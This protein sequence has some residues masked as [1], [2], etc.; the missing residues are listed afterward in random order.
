MITPSFLAR[1][2]ARKRALEQL[3]GTTA[4]ILFVP[5]VFGISIIQ[6]RLQDM[7]GVPVVGICET[8]FTGTN[9][10]VKRLSDIAL[11]S[12]ILVL[13]PLSAF[14]AMN[15]AALHLI[16]HSLYKAHAFL[17]ASSIVRE[18]RTDR[19]GAPRS[20]AVSIRICFT[21]SGS[22]SGLA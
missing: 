5:D 7:N 1:V 19:P 21:V 22:R 17:S 18:S 4:T 3:Q 6:G 10:L 2:E 16:G 12:V 8:P 15:Q 13:Y 11:A 14:R 9:E 20:T